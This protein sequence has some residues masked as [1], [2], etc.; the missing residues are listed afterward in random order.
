MTEINCSELKRFIRK[1]SGPEILD[2]KTEMYVRLY[3]MGTV[4]LTCE[5]ILG[6]YEASP[7]ELAAIY[8]K[9]LPEPLWPLL[10]R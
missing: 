9:S 2:R 6:K 10:L 1:V 5:W 3:C 4:C 8:E 7:E